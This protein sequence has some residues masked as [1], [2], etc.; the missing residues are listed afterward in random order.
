MHHAI[1]AQRRVG[2]IHDQSF[3]GRIKRTT[4]LRFGYYLVIYYWGY[5]VRD[6]VRDVVHDVC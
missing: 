3:P 1:S 6:V 2:L 4:R 5:V